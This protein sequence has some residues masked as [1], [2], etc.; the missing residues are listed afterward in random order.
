MIKVQ[1]GDVFKIIGLLVIFTDFE[2]G[3]IIIACSFLSL[4]ASSILISLNVYNSM[5]LLHVLD[6]FNYKSS[7]DI[8]DEISIGF[9]YYYLTAVFIQLL[10]TIEI[11]SIMKI[12]IFPQICINEPEYAEY[13]N[14]ID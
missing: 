9:I 5:V 2:V 3:S 7:T 8:I 10:S 4:K 14:G 1:I 13:S 12:Q 11:V 6:L